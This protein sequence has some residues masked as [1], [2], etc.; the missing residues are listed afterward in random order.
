MPEVGFVPE[1]HP[2]PPP[3]IPLDVINKGISDL[4][5]DTEEAE[6][7]N[8]RDGEVPIGKGTPLPFLVLTDRH[9]F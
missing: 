3:P 2:P 9:I 8:S 1:Q 5:R 7:V 6:E 4:L